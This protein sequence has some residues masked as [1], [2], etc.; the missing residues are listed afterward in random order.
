LVLGRIVG[1]ALDFLKGARVILLI[2]VVNDDCFMY[3]DILCEADALIDL[4]EALEELEDGILAGLAEGGSML[5]QDLI[6]PFLFGRDILLKGAGLG[7]GGGYRKILLQRVALIQ[8]ELD[9]P[10]VE[11]HALWVKVLSLWVNGHRDPV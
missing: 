6:E 7:W 11:K 8:L 3:A 10:G 4:P 5:L 1:I 2:D 9:N